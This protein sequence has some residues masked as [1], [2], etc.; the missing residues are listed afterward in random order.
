M[1]II[2]LSENLY[3][4]KGGAELSILT[5]LSELSKKNMV[6]AFCIGEENRIIKKRNLIIHIIKKPKIFDQTFILSK[7]LRVIVNINY[8]LNIWWKYFLKKIIDKI[9]PDI[10]ITQLNLVPSSIEIANDKT[11]KI[12]FVRSYEHICPEG[13]IKGVN[14]CDGNCFMCTSLHRKFRYPF[15]VKLLKW[16]KKSFNKSDIIIANSI[17]MKKILQKFISNKIYVIFFS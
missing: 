11:K 1:K 13:F 5:L 2:F 8:F 3:P 16:H 9:K 10:L 7:I 4:P 15:T 12:I 6:I 17:F 14:N